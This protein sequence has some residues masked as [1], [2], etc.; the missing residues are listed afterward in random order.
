[1][2]AIR[3]Y[4]GLG[5]NLGEPVRQL[6]RARAAIADLDGVK[7]AA[8]SSLYRSRPMGPQDQ[9]DYVNAVMAVDTELAAPQLLSE[10]QAIEAAQGRVREGD[11]WG[12]RTLD[13]DLLLYGRACIR[14]EDLTVP[15]YGL[16]ERCFVLLPLAEIA[17]ADL[18]VP[19]HGPLSEL[20]RHCPAEG[21]ERL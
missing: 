2:T 19:G 18:Y 8:F 16:A 5:S 9:P 4:I 14:T 15:H 12:P 6:E 13:L 7:E 17:P 1:M 3:A 11:R 20:V 21:L 10:L